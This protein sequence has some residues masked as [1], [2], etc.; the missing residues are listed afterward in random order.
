MAKLVA[1]LSLMLAAA[2]CAKKPVERF[3][4]LSEE[5]V[6][7]T[8]SF[9]PSAAT[10]AGLHK[11][12]DRTLDELLDDLSPSNIARQRNFYL[13]FR[14]RLERLKSD[15]LSAEDRADWQI[16]EDQISLALLEFDEIRNYMHNPATYVETLGNALFTPYVLEYAPKGE[17]A[18]HIIS[19]LKTVPL[20]LDQA[21]SN[22]TSAPAIW[23][24]V[25]MEEN[26]GNIDLVDKTIR[27]WVPEG[28]REIYSR[29]AQPALMAMRRF[30]DYLKANLVPRDDYSWRLGGK[31]YPTKFRYLLESGIEA[32]NAL[33]MAETEL[34][35][36][37]EHM[38]A[39]ALPLHKQMFPG[40]PEHTDL[41]GDARE[42]R[43]V[44][45]VLAKIAERHSTRESYMDDARQDLAEARAFVENK[46]L[47]TLPSRANLQVIPTPEFMRGVYSVGGFNAA[48][49]LEPQLGAFYWVTPIPPDWPKERTDSKLREYNFYKLKL[50][51]IHEA[52]PGHYVQME[53]A[54]DV[55]PPFRRLLRSVF[56]NG[57]YIEGWAE[58]VTRTMIEQ[59]FLDHS[60][61][62]ALTFAKEELRVLANT[63]LDVRLQM[64]DMTD[65]EALD[66][67][68]QQTFQE[69]EEAVEKLQRAKL[70]SCQLPMYFLG[71][72]GWSQVRNDYRQASGESFSISGFNDRALKEGAVPLPVLG[73]LLK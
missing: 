72:R 29:A 19:R 65:Q 26:Q 52:M 63:I 5:F 18:N 16:L 35:Q 15:Q 11:Y 3:A 14:E 8:L 57:P 33:L 55:Q 73:G 20:F 23:A 36:V 30:Q 34:K 67:M 71:W 6:Y 64:L 45:E 25:A 41:A 28:Q 49:A 12:Q 51:T 59:G 53:V 24:N 21:R 39:L 68:E 56:G 38:L 43:V 70:S 61:E 27:I 48:P 10:A 60:P 9:S 54:N 2:G 32:D 40:H 69:H 37:R 46:H 62:L 44:G 66:L 22:I 47:L 7:T 1:L 4:A 58:F 42:N 17:R 13:A 50:L 31:N